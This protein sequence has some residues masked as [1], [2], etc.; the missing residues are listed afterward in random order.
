MSCA[1]GLALSLAARLSA[2]APGERKRRGAKGRGSLAM[3]SLTSYDRPF[4]AQRFAP[5][6]LIDPLFTPYLVLF[7]H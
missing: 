6:K 7:P 4:D 1:G 2:A 3:N 5:A